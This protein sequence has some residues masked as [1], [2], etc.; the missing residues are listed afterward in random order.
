MQR[1]AASSC[2]P[3]ASGVLLWLRHVNGLR[4]GRAARLVH[5]E[6]HGI[7]GLERRQ[8]ISA[9]SKFWCGK[10]IPTSFVPYHQFLLY[11]L[12]SRAP[13]KSSLDEMKSIFIF[14]RVRS[15]HFST[16]AVCKPRLALGAEDITLQQLVRTH[17]SL[18]HTHIA[19]LFN[20]S[21]L[22]TPRSQS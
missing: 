19:H 12:R 6:S 8:M 1:K 18:A 14:S 2:L 5:T 11:S 4:H 7:S 3:W 16:M 15:R 20:R 21:A 22:A 10:N 9:V 13:R 17:P